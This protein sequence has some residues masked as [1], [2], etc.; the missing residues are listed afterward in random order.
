M[1]V[2]STFEL[3]PGDTSRAE[4]MIADTMPLYLCAIK[5]SCDCGLAQKNPCAE[6]ERH[7]D[8]VVT[9]VALCSCAIRAPGQKRE[10]ILPWPAHL[11]VHQRFSNAIRSRCC[12]VD[13]VCL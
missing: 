8:D 1:S 10:V 13:E 3:G 9:A 2:S 7:R 5:Q 12:K 4:E 6:L 11:Q